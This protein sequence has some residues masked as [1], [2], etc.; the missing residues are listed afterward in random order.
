MNNPDT[1]SVVIADDHAIVRDGLTFLLSGESDIEVVGQGSNGKEAL[2]LV[3]KHHPDIAI[4]DINMPEMNGVEA[5][6][7]IKGV[8]PNTDVIILSMYADEEYVQEVVRAGARGYVIKQTA[9]SAILAAV[10]AVC[11]GQIYFSP[12]V[13]S[14][15]MGILQS[16]GKTV[17]ANADNSSLSNRERE[18]LQLVAE[19]FT[20]NEIAGKLHV[21]P[22]T[23]ETHRQRIMNKL[24]LHDI[25]SLTRYAFE[26]R[27]IN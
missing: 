9:S 26:K 3:E 27:I 11:K 16:Q 7:Q 1:I 8:V 20:T 12:E 5:T 2:E 21:S 18:V 4:L 6:R 15:V 19:G 22:K 23:V 17:E 14:T 25:A 24:D 13:S 10:R